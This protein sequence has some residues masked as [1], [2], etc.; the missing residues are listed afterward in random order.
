M[1]VE[2]LVKTKRILTRELKTGM[3]LG[4]NLYAPN[5]RDLLLH[6]GTLLSRDIIEGIAKRDIPDVVILSDSEKHVSELM[7]PLPNDAVKKN[8]VHFTYPE[9]VEDLILMEYEGSMILKLDD[10]L[11]EA[12]RKKAVKTAKWILQEVSKGAKPQVEAAQATVKDLIDTVSHNKSAFLNITGV[13]MIDEY[14]FVHSVNVAAYT[15]VIALESGVQTDELETICTGALLHDVGKMLIDQKILN[16]K[17]RLTDEEFTEI[18]TH[19]EKGYDILR[20]NS[21][22]EKTAV[23]AKSHHERCNGS[24]YPTGLD[25]SNSPVSIQ[26]AAIADVYDALTSDRVYK[27]AMPAGDAMKI[28]V[29]ETG[30]HF[31]ADLVSLFQRTIGIYPIG[32]YVEL[33]NGFVARVLEQNKGIVRPIVQLIADSKGN[34]L[35]DRTVLNLMDHEDIYIDRGIPASEG[36]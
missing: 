10:P 35:E 31:N 16:K 33:N 30:K 12:T 28:I 15:T 26:M 21:I 5:G 14:T 29:S 18:K 1:F 2:L 20:K 9:S 6:E 25:S 23:L 34:E 8:D 19:A 13:R 7:I 11:V 4:V 24:G 27:K 17:G 3:K 36:I 22:D 32:S